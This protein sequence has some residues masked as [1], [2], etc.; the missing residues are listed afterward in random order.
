MPRGRFPDRPSRAGIP[1]QLPRTGS[2]RCSRSLF[3]AAS[4]ARYR[5]VR[6][7]SQATGDKHVQKLRGQYGKRWPQEPQRQSAPITWRGRTTTAAT[8]P[9]MI[10]GVAS[11]RSCALDRLT[12]CTPWLLMAASCTPAPARSRHQA[13]RPGTGCHVHRSSASHAGILIRPG[14]PRE[15]GRARWPPPFPARRRGKPAP[16]HGMARARGRLFNDYP[17]PHPHGAPAPR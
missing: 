15:G 5:R 9:K 3:Q 14:F 4:I 7:Y 13:L 8:A 17:R 11:S 2:W 12:T 1:G 16:V 10:N 6:H